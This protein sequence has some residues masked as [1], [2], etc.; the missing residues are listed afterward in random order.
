[1]T[2]HGTPQIQYRLGHVLA[3]VRVVI[4]IWGFEQNRDRLKLPNNSMAFEVTECRDFHNPFID[5]H[6]GN[7]D[8]G[9]WTNEEALF[10]D[11]SIDRVK[12]G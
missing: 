8:L 12:K 10:R 4:F 3:F 2:H 11:L 1:M 6:L 7:L 5:M 9:V